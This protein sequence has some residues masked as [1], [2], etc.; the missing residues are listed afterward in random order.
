MSQE[1]QDYEGLDMDDQEETNQEPKMDE[2]T[3]PKTSIYKITVDVRAIQHYYKDVFVEAMNEA[4]AREIALADPTIP[5]EDD[6]PSGLIADPNSGWWC[7]P[8]YVD[9]VLMDDSDLEVLIDDVPDG[10]LEEI[11]ESI[12]SGPNTEIDLEEAINLFNSTNR[13]STE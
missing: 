1:S 13:G 6:D 11:V 2:A 4:E 8:A 9:E 5:D 3:V 10:T 7:A 12:Q